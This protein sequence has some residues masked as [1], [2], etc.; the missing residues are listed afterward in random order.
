MF[1]FKITE[2]L[3]YISRDDDGIIY[4]HNSGKTEVY[5]H[6]SAVCNAGLPT[7]VDPMSIIALKARR[8]LERDHAIILH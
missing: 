7:P 2:K 4:A 6:Q 8:R 5:Y 1:H 3:V